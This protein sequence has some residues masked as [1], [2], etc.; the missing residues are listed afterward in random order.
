MLQLP[1]MVSSFISTPVV[2]RL[3]FPDHSNTI[4]VIASIIY[5]ALV[6]YDVLFFAVIAFGKSAN[7]PLRTA[8]II[9]SILALL[10]IAKNVSIFYF[11]ADLAESIGSNGYMALLGIANTLLLVFGLISTGLFFGAIS[12][13]ARPSGGSSIPKE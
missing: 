9:G 5:L 2:Q 3:I 1:L 12:F 10:D 7:K 4:N 8:A 13:S 11:T 6:L